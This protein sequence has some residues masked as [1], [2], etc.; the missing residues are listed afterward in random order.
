[1][2][3]E[4]LFFALPGWGLVTVLLNCGFLAHCFTRL[5]FL[6]TSPS[7]SD[8]T[9]KLGGFPMRIRALLIA[10]LIAAASILIATPAQ[11]APATVYIYKVYFDSPGSDRGSNTSLNAEYV[12]IKNGDD[13]SHSIS[14]WTVR[15]KAGHR[16]TFPDGFRLGAGKQA[17]IHTGDGTSYTTSASTHL[18]WGREWYVWNNTGDKVILRRADGSLK[19]T[20]SYS[21][22]GSKKYC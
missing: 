20:C 8:P 12:V 22:A 2:A 7:G 4:S 16:Y 17:I 18:Y 10:C 3:I 15:D 9:V 11:A 6:I 5:R 1:V 13:V 19:D 14:G 21:G